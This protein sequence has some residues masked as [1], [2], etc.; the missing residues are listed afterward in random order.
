LIAILHLYNNL[1]AVVCLAKDIID[2]G[3]IFDI[4]FYLLFVEISQVGNGPFSFQQAV[5]KIDE[6][7][8]AVFFA[9]YPFKPKVAERFYTFLHTFSCTLILSGKIR[10]T[11]RS[12][13]IKL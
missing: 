13:W 1:I 5:Q 2:D 3:T 10:L 11:R 4:S 6:K 9:E 7:N 12:P 8:F